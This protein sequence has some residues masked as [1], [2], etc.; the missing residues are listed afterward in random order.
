MRVPRK[1]KDSR[2]EKSRNY[3]CVC[4]LRR[5]VCAGNSQGPVSSRVRSFTLKTE[6]RFPVTP[7]LKRRLFRC[8]H[9]GHRLRFG[10]RDCGACYQA[11]PWINRYGFWLCALAALVVTALIVA[12]AL[13]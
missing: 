9:C 13:H 5:H 6:R 8:T 11:T 7:F 12:G 10:Q 4:G 1:Y 3:H 2:L